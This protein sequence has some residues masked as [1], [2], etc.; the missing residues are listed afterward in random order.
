MMSEFSAGAVRP[1]DCLR[2]G[3]TL[4]KD[5]YL[6][7]LLITFVGVLIAG[8][9][10]IVFIGPMY[11]GIFFSLLRKMDTGQAEF[12][13][14]F[15]G[16]ERFVPSLVV[17]VFFIL[18]VFAVMILLFGGFL[19]SAAGFSAMMPG[20]QREAALSASLLAMGIPLALA[21]LLVSLVQSLALFAYPLTM[22]RGL[23]GAESIK[24]SAR[25]VWANLGGIFGLLA[26]Q[27]VVAIGGLL[28]CGIG[29]YLVM[30]LLF[31]MVAV[32][33]RQVFPNG[34]G[35]HV[36]QTRTAF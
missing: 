23:S 20:D 18:P 29:V 26:L 31:A 14:L 4:V 12:G 15:K 5:S 3:W 30:P 13:D 22:E 17:S 6:V 28:L 34:G 19:L 11:C 1:V 7:F 16:F 21:I 25:A 36:T 35:H 8:T 27:F 33:Y 10:P 2:D 9:V 32:A 24:L